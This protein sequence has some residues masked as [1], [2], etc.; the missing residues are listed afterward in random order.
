MINH[1][2]RLQFQNVHYQPRQS[3]QHQQGVQAKSQK[4][5]RKLVYLHLVLNDK[6]QE[7]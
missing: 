3:S 4:D 1:V 2:V 5:Q 7:L 6:E